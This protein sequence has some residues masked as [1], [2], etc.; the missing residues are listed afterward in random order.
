MRNALCSICLLFSGMLPLAG[1]SDSA[2]DKPRKPGRSAWFACISALPEGVENPVKVMSGKDLTKLEIPSYM[3]SD[4]VKI[5]DDGILRIVREVPDPEDPK[6]TKYLVLAEAKVPEGVREALIILLPLPKLEGDLVFQAKV[7]DLATFKGG[8]RL[9]INLSDTHIRV[10]LGAT[11][12]SV[13]PGQANIYESP[14]L[15][16]PANIPIMYEFYDPGQKKWKLITASTIVL[17]PTRREICIFNSGSRLGNIKNHK[18]LFPVQ[19]E[20]KGAAISE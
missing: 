14:V 12:V 3:T 11:E 7:Q 2:G 6:K 10:K 5:A 9:F 18:I 13:V 16:K 20:P 8:D 19:A 4:P 17:R 1:Q 15:T